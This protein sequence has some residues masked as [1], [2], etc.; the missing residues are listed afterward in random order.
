MALGFRDPDAIA[1]R[2]VTERA[3]LADFVQF[4]SGDASST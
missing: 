3:E 1:N 2:L 4:H